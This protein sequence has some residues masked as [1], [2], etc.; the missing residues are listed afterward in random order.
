MEDC[1]LKFI[2][3]I[4]KSCLFILCVHILALK[5][6]FPRHLKCNAICD[7][8]NN[9]PVD[10]G[11]FFN[12]LHLIWVFDKYYR[13]TECCRINLD[14]SSI[15]GCVVLHQCLP[16]SDSCFVL[17]PSDFLVNTSKVYLCTRRAEKTVQI[18][19]SFTFNSSL[20]LHHTHH[21][22]QSGCTECQKVLSG[23]VR[24]TLKCCTRG[25]IILK[26]KLVSQSTYCPKLASFSA[27]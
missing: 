6:T 14:S 23:L 11:F 13:Q 10:R 17:L 3:S 22:R 7:T 9:C 8:I 18:G 24:S 5:N 19:R 15:K 25:I 1:A 21:R 26:H 20:Y 4:I 27:T 12:F 2:N 16:F